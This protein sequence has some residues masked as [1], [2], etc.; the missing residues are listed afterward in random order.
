MANPLLTHARLQPQSPTELTRA[1]EPLC[2]A[3][4]TLACQ[5]LGYGL[6]LRL[7]D[8]GLEA[9]GTALLEGACQQGATRACTG[10]A[11]L[12]LT[13]EEGGLGAASRGCEQRDPAACLVL[14]AHQL[15]RGDSPAAALPALQRACAMGQPWGCA[16]EAYLEAGKPHTTATLGTAASMLS[17][18]CKK[19]DADACADRGLLSAVGMYGEPSPAKARPWYETGCEAG[20]P[21]A[22]KH[23]GVQLHLGVG[24]PADPG[25]AAGLLAV[26]CAKGLAEACSIAPSMQQSTLEEGCAAGSPEA[27]GLLGQQVEPA[28]GGEL[29]HS[30]CLAGYA[31]ACSVLMER[32]DAGGA[33]E[34]GLLATQACA[35]GRVEA[36]H[37]AAMAYLA[38]ESPLRSPT[39][40]VTLLMEPC[41]W[42]DQPS[43]ACLSSLAGVDSEGGALVASCAGLD[44][45]GACRGPE[46]EACGELGLAL[47]YGTLPGLGERPSEGEA[48][49]RRAC[50][51][52]HA[53]SCH[54]LAD[55]LLSERGISHEPERALALREAGC[56]RGV[57]LD[58]AD[59]AGM[60]NVGLV[61][62]YSP[63]KALE[64][65][66]RACA[67]GHAASCRGEWTL[68]RAR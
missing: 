16:W 2:L 53:G 9:R 4:N 29:L 3:G 58:C 24:G 1:L 28:R 34:R 48:L 27:C 23:L 47:T 61:V 54:T 46:A 39:T 6:A 38:P 44:P 20:D 55:V 30:A 40:A 10:L 26:A 15:E 25:R 65:Q 67:L 49:L 64:H 18:A 7:D 59:L 66:Q 63:Q 45:I 8:A 50:E 13:L 42:G 35:E 14:G 36:C 21:V 60:Y 33:L 32:E 57:A 56:E 31:P 37:I 41:G 51:A 62:S 52:G 12:Q 5:S 43:C 19:G 11:A 17:K 68:I 22:C